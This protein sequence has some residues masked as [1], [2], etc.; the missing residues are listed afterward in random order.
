MKSSDLLRFNEYAM[1]YT[2]RDSLWEKVELY[3]K[4][5]LKSDRFDPVT[6]DGEDRIDF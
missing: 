2:K 6:V 1:K 3:A 5:I 4:M